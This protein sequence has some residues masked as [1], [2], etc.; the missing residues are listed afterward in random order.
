MLALLPYAPEHVDTAH[1]VHR[2]NAHGHPEVVDRLVHSCGGR[3][4]FDQEL[5][6]AHVRHHHPIADEAPAVAHDNA[7]FAELLCQRQRGRDHLFAGP[8]APDDF[9]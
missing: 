1:V 5:R 3:P 7:N 8:R 2:E 6:F 4:L 9:D